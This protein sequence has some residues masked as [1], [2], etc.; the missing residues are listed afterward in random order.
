MCSRLNL[1]YMYSVW[2]FVYSIYYI[3]II[4]CITLGVISVFEDV[5]NEYMRMIE[6]F[7]SPAQVRWEAKEYCL[8]LTEEI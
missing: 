7:I 3:F 8:H 1:Y 5:I 4:R 2:K 6:I